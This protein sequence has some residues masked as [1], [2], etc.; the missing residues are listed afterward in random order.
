[1]ERLLATV[2]EKPAVVLERLPRGGGATRWFSC[3]TA[4]ELRSVFAVLRPASRVSFYFDGRISQ[5]S[6]DARLAETV[7]RLL[8]DQGE[9][10]LGTM[11]ADGVE[12]DV[13]FPSTIH[14]VD[15]QLAAAGSPAR[16]FVGQFPAADNNDRDA[17]TVLVPDADGS[18]R[19]ESH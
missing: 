17:F 14:E 15:A 5:C 4:A 16:V 8:V 2:L 3:E 7:A 1:M 10:V 13:D 19:S 6:Y 18:V 12:I 9:I 11:S